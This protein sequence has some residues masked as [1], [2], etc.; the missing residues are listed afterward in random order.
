MAA[1]NRYIAWTR[2]RPISS[3]FG[4]TMMSVLRIPTHLIGF[5]YK[6]S[7]NVSAAL[8][9]P[10]TCTWSSYGFFN[11][12]GERSQFMPVLGTPIEKYYSGL[13]KAAA[14]VLVSRYL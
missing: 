13:R 9:A 2:R 14:M 7:N 6:S 4:S 11:D 3:R 12:P 8:G 5:S 1:A 10:D